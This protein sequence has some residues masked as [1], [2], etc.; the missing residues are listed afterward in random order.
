MDYV[1][2]KYKNPYISDGNLYEKQK[3][4]GIYIK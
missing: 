4:G 1:K 2:R 3:M